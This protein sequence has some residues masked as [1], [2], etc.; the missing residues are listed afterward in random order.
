MILTHLLTFRNDFFLLHGITSAWALSN[1]LPA[2]K[3]EEAR[4]RTCQNFICILL[5]VYICK[6]RPNLN[7]EYLGTSDEPEI[8]WDQL[9]AKVL[10]KPVTFEEHRFKLVQV[11]FEMLSLINQHR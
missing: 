9:L 4:I 3:S 2:L 7:P 11:L 8:S 10:A 6:D 5:G 1:I